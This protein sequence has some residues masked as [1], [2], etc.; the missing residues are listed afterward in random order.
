MRL[1]G[2][3][4]WFELGSP[5]GEPHIGWRRGAKY[6]IERKVNENGEVIWFGEATNWMRN[7]EG[8]WSFLDTNKNVMPLEDYLPDIVYP[9]TRNMWTPCDPPEYE[10][11]YQQLKVKQ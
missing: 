7:V 10:V 6:H 4:E 5:I 9:E 8:V 1:T 11:L 3:S 2:K